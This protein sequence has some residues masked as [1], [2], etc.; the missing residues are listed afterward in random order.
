MATY[1][2]EVLVMNLGLESLKAAL[3]NSVE[4]GHHI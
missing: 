2:T 3:L 1:I 4:N